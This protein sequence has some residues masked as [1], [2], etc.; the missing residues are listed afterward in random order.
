[1][2]PMSAAEH[3]PY[4]DELIENGFTKI[5]FDLTDSINQLVADLKELTYQQTQKKI[6]S[7]DEVHLALDE[8]K[9]N[10]FRL[11]A[12]KLINTSAFKNSF[13]E[14]ISPFFSSVLGE[15]LAYQ[16]NLNLILVTPQDKTSILPLH[17]DTW[18]GHSRYELA[19]LF[20]LTSVLPAQNMFILPLPAWRN[21][22]DLI[23][24]AQNLQQL[25]ETLGD[26]FHHLNLKP[27][28]ALIFW[29]N[30]PHGNKINQSQQTHW[31]INLRLKNIFTPYKEKGLGDYFI[32]Y[33]L[34]RFNEFVFKE[35]T[36]ESKN[37]R[38]HYK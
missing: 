4:L 23:G 14:K 22:R 38:L 33:K 37:S 28:E 3:A 20:P 30:L 18:T 5:S 17:A 26:S 15:D 35:S 24:D 12:I 29:H 25:T 21:C 19:I 27:G 1:M 31:S 6:S 16:K 8:D 36:Y 2:S 32:P 9:I 34:S 13:I 7:L 10:S 11:G